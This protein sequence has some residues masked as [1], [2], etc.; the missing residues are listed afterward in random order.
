LA[1][2][3]ANVS[4]GDTI[5]GTIIAAGGINASGSSVDASLLSEGTINTSG[6]SSG[7]QKGFAQG[8]AGDATSQ[9]LANDASAKAASSDDSNKDD[10]NKG[11]Q[12]RLGQKVSRVTVVLP[13]KNKS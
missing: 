8:S 1:G 12:I 4:A 9:G 10:K 3:S 11:K 2:G 7:A 6:D 5:S 13:P